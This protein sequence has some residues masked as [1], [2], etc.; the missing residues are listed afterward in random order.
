[1]FADLKGKRIATPQYGNTQDVAAR[2]YV[3]SDLKE[4]D[5]TDVL[6][7][8][9]AEQS[10]LMSRKQIDAAWVPEPWGSRLIAE[11]GATLVGEEKDLWPGKQFSLTVVV[12]TPEF[13]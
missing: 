13:L 6:A 10:G 9:N 11:T 5:A 8:A 7:I 2:H 12:T 1:S 4:S 3:V